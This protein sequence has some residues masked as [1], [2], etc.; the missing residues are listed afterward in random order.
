MLR[1]GYTLL[2]VADVKQT[3]DFYAAAFGIPC[4]FQADSGDYAELETGGTALG[5]VAL[6][7]A[8]SNGTPHTID[9]PAGKS[10]AMEIGLLS[11]DVAASYAKAVAAGAIATVP[12]KQ[13]PW[14]Q[15]VAYVRDN[16]GFLVEIC[17]PMG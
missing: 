1:F 17:S 9:L 12:P 8:D 14:G 4:R 7:L 16:N 10:P 6:R 11:D 13:K 15:T 2:Y 5:F 3:V